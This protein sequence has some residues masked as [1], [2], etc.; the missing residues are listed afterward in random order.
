MKTLILFSILALISVKALTQPDKV[1]KIKRLHDQ[2]VEFFTKRLNLTRD[3]SKEF[4][5]VYNDYQ[6]RKNLIAQERKNTI[7]YFTENSENIRDKES[8]ELLNKYVN[9]QKRE[10]KLLEDYTNKF[11]EF[12]PEKKVVQVFILEVQFRQ[13]LL[14]IHMK[15][16]PNV[17]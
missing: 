3:E 1:D 10:T 8:A 2:K 13:W 12:L 9:Y 11:R 5:P 17:R 7:K 6:S 14:K 15:P 4:W 16:R